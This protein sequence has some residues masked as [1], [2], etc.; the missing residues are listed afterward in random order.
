MQNRQ[1]NAIFLG[2]VI[3]K[4][5]K[6]EPAKIVSRYNDL[7]QI[8]DNTN[9]L[10]YLIGGYFNRSK[11]FL[12]QARLRSVVEMK[13]CRMIDENKDVIMNAL[14]SYVQAYLSSAAQGDC[15]DSKSELSM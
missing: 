12:N 15:L 11:F 7:D 1:V 6:E 14:L 10:L 3:G 2:Q 5:L 8:Y 9:G 13:L 4:D